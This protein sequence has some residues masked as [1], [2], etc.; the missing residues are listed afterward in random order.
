MVD[1]S[2]IIVSWNVE[3]LLNKCLASIYRNQGNVTTEIF[4]ID[5]ASTDKTVPM[6]KSF[7]PEVDLTV[8]PKNYGFAAANNQGMIKSRGKYVLLLN[9]DTELMAGT[10]EK[11]YQFMEKNSKIGVAGCKHLNS[12]LTLQA[13]VRSFPTVKPILLIFTKLAKLMPGLK[14]LNQYLLKDFNYKFSTTVDQVAGSFFM[15][16]HE[17][18]DQ[19][20][21]LDERFFIW[22]E[23]VDFCKRVKEAGWEVWYNH[24][25]Q[26]VH[27]GG[28]SFSQELTIKKQVIFFKSAWYYFQ[29][30]GFKWK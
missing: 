17:I 15:I 25:A 29:K 22:F 27:H 7:Y 20:G 13:S 4:V 8:N 26:I 28:Q 9:P 6:I 23:E 3:N 18:I 14:S 11:M 10:L 19:I 30:H 24:A 21:G 12:D 16:R 2:I 1:I 5:N